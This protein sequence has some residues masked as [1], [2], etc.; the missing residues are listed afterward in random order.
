MTPPPTS[1]DGTDITGATIDGQEVQEITVDGDTVFTAGPEIPD[2]EVD[3]FERSSLVHYSGQ[4]GSY[5]TTTDESTQGNRSLTSTNTFGD[6]IIFSELG[7]GLPNYP[8]RGDKILYDFKNRDGNERALFSF[9]RE[10]T[11]RFGNGYIIVGNSIANEIVIKEDGGQSETIFSGSFDG[12]FN[13]VLIETDNNSINAT[14]YGGSPNTAPEIDEANE[15]GS[16][17]LNSSQYNGRGV[18]FEASQRDFGGRVF[19]DNINTT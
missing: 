8:K 11:S 4:T 19:F 15:L 1:I 2:S 6:I 14:V 3:Y 18:G 7:D 12:V 16:A 17:T 9:F 13:R 10:D 5:N